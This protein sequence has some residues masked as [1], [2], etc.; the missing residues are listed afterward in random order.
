M[1]S[2]RFWMSPPSSSCDISPAVGELLAALAAELTPKMLQHAT[3]STARTSALVRFA[4][5]TRKRRCR[6]CPDSVVEEGWNYKHKWNAPRSRRAFRAGQ[7]H[8]G[9][10][11]HILWRR[12]QPPHGHRSLEPLALFVHTSSHSRTLLQPKRQLRVATLQPLHVYPLDVDQ[13]A[14]CHRCYGSLAHLRA[15]R[16]VQDG[17]LAEE[18]A[19]G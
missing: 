13:P 10:A 17:H 2:W 8:L 3:H 19:V 4:S 16:V 12:Q 7:T 9:P 15:C 6:A 18:S 5:H 14:V 11:K 1:S